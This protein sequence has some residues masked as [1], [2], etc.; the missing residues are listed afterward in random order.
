MTKSAAG[1]KSARR[2]PRAYA[3]PAGRTTLG[4]SASTFPVTVGLNRSST[5]AG[6][7]GSTSSTSAAWRCSSRTAPLAVNAATSTRSSLA[8]PR[9][10][11]RAEGRVRAPRRAHDAVQRRRP[12]RSGRHAGWRRQLRR[13]RRAPRERARRVAAAGRQLHPEL[14]L[15]GVRR[16]RGAPEQSRPAREPRR[17]AAV[18]GRSLHARRRQPRE[19]RSA[20]RPP[21][22][23][24][25]QAGTMSGPSRAAGA[26]RSRTS[27][28]TTTRSGDGLKSGTL[29]R[30]AFGAPAAER[31]LA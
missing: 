23:G 16:A 7:T 15:P 8:K 29:R 13:G 1:R 9:R 17:R 26:V 31:I 24:A 11:R 27:S 10:Q 28:R 19:R 6:T 18:P 12:L 5:S 3:G 25:A 4:C 21:R 20:V 14:P 2:A 30:H 22:A